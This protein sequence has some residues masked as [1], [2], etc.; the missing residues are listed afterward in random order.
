MLLP[1]NDATFCL[2]CYLLRMMLG[3]VNA[4]SLRYKQLPINLKLRMIAASELV[5]IYRQ[6][7]VFLLDNNSDNSNNNANELGISLIKQPN[8]GIISYPINCNSEN[9]DADDRNWDFKHHKLKKSF[10]SFCW[11]V[12]FSPP[13]E[14]KALKAVFSASINS[15][16]V[17]TLCKSQ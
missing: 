1:A 17:C 8:T 9:L 16:N 5:A 13:R 4:S 11:D 6:P 14:K 3:A 10:L 2:C 7:I 15:S 12:F